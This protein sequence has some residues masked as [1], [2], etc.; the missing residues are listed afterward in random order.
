MLLDNVRQMREQGMSDAGIIQN[1]REQGYNAREID[2][3]INQSRIKSAV[4][5]EIPNSG[6]QDMQ[7]SMMTQEIEPQQMQAMQPQFQPQ[8]QEIPYQSYPQYPAYQQEAAYSQQNTSEMI[9]DIADQIVSEKLSE[10]KK[11]IFGIADFK[12]VMEARVAGIDERLKK[13]EKIIEQLQMSILNRIG[14]YSQSLQDVKSEMNMMQ[15]SFSKVINPLADKAG[16]KEDKNENQEKETESE[17][18]RQKRKKCDDGF[19]SYLKR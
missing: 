9:S 16:L 13:I 5:E 7:Q 6:M 4:N 10:I 14:N 8:P 3:A 17:E 2:D 15:E 1:L 18:P 11:A 12:S 19:E